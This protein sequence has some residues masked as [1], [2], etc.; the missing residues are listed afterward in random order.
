M[1]PFTLAGILLVLLGVLGLAGG[2][3]HYRRAV[4]RENRLPEEQRRPV[5]SQMILPIAGSFAI[6][7]G[8]VMLAVGERS[9]DSLL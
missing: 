9:H 5:D 4:D 7:T 2:S 6:L 8:I 1:K 3:Y